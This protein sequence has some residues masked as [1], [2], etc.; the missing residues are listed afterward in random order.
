METRVEERTP[1]LGHDLLLLLK[2]MGGTARTEA[3]R[4]A[5]AGA[6]GADAVYGNCHGDRFSFDE[7]LVF[8]ASKGK[9]DLLGDDVFLGS[10]PACSGH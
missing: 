2:N 10:A 9:L 3:L 8:L 7:A 5:A 6:F 1:V 4:N